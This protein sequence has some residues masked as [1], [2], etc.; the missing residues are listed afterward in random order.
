M[1]RCSG[2]AM[3]RC[4]PW[5]HR[6]GRDLP[7]MPATLRGGPAVVSGSGPLFPLT[8]LAWCRTE[9]TAAT[10]CHSIPPLA[11]PRCI[12]HCGKA[13]PYEPS[14]VSAAAVQPALMQLVYAS[15]V[16]LPVCSPAQR[17]VY[18]ARVRQ[19]PRTHDAAGQL[20]SGTT[21]AESGRGVEN[22][23]PGS[24]AGCARLCGR[25]TARGVAGASSTR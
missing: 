25:R 20:T 7:A 8:T 15:D 1:Q 22:R 10:W 9:P 14:A 18:T 12:D 21:G 24:P 3:Q 6:S 19:A 2:A 13:V 4:N 16:Q 17:K 23:A 5:R 11:R